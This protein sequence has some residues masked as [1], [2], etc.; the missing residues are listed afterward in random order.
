[1]CSSASRARRSRVAPSCRRT[2]SVRARPPLRTYGSCPR[3]ADYIRLSTTV[4]T[5]ALLERKGQQHALL[6]TRGFGDALLIGNQSRP[7]IF[8]LNIRRPAPLYGAVLEVDERVTL[9]GYASDPAAEAHAVRFDESGKVE[10][11][12]RGKGWDGEGDAEGPGEIVRGL[13]GEA[14][15]ILKKPGTFP[16]RGARQASRS[17]SSQTRIRSVPTYS[18]STTTASGAWRSCLCT[19]TRTRRTS[20]CWAGSPARWASRMSP[21]APRCC[22]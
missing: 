21:R 19:A 13:S 16:S 1:V 20:S 10:R 17:R 18:D 8:D 15:R 4:A 22:R 3:G 14:V 9:V 7:R 2:R 11:G 12:Y 6:I 5:N